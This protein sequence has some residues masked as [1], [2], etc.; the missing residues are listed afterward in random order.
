MLKFWNRE[1]CEQFQ[2]MHFGVSCATCERSDEE[3]P[4]HPHVSNSR[5]S[6]GAG[7]RLLQSHPVPAR[8][9]FRWEIVQ[10]RI[11]GGWPT[12]TRHKPRVAHPLRSW[13]RVSMPDCRS[14]GLSFPCKAH[15]AKRQVHIPH[16]PDLATPTLCKERKG[17]ATRVCLA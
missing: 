11:N 13:Q 5:H 9:I 10:G 3:C 8:R 7:N 17:W 15:G 14:F 4:W 12:R 16:G 2:M 1:E 6:L